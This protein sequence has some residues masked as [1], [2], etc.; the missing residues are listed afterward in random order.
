MVVGA[1]KRTSHCLRGARG[2]ESL[3]DIYLLDVSFSFCSMPC[4][5]LRVTAALRALRV[6]SLTVR[7]TVSHGGHC[8]NVTI[9]VKGGSNNRGIERET[10]PHLINPQTFDAV[11]QQE[12]VSKPD[13]IFI[14][15]QLDGL[16]QFFRSV[17]G[18]SPPR[19]TLQTGLLDRCDLDRQFEADPDKKKSVLPI[20]ALWTL[21]ALISV[22]S[23]FTPIHRFAWL[24]INLSS[25][26]EEPAF[27]SRP[28][29]NLVLV[30][31]LLQC[32][33]RNCPRIDAKTCL[34]G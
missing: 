30:S 15:G 3:R 13:W 18:R 21:P 6:Y 19:L 9:N 7:R 8:S 16:S 26:H 11:G 32:V 1:G 17:A 14:L 2:D 10:R 22:R 34:R 23:L 20:A 28:L 24:F 31:V 12:L 27:L 25:F 33:L 5:C 4:L 29:G